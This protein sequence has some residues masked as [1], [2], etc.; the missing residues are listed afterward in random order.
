MPKKV[1]VTTG[2]RIL[3][4]QVTGGC[5]AALLA[6]SLVFTIAVAHAQS[7]APAPVP[8]TPPQS[9]AT[10][11]AETLPAILRDM[12]TALSL[13][14]SGQM[15][16]ARRLADDI[17]ARLRRLG[18]PGTILLAPA[19][20]MRASIAMQLGDDRTAES[21]FRSAIALREKTNGPNNVE[22]A[23]ALSGLLDLFMKRARYGEAEKLLRRVMAI[24]AANLPPNHPDRLFSFVTQANLDYALGRLEAA[25][26]TLKRVVAALRTHHPEH[27]YFGVALNNLGQVQVNLGL[28]STAEKT[29]NEV[30]AFQRKLSGPKS[31]LVAVA[32]NNLAG[33]YLRQGRYD[34]AERLHRAELRLMEERGGDSQELAKSISNLANVLSA[35]GRLREARVLMARALK[36][37]ERTLPPYHPLIATALNNLASVSANKTTAHY[38]TI[39]AML[40]RA[41]DI[42]T[43][44]YGNRHPLIA[45]ALNN[46][47]VSAFNQKRYG[48]A[49]TFARRAVKIV[50]V[51]FQGAHPE[52]ARALSTLATILN[53]RGKLE[54][55][56]SIQREAIRL[57]L[58]VLGPDHPDLALSWMNMASNALD[59]KDWKEAFDAGRRAS[60]IVARR[61]RAIIGSARGETENAI[62][63]L[64]V[65]RDS[66]LMV[67]VA[68]ERLSRTASPRD[69]KTLRNIAF[70]AAQVAGNNAANRALLRA[71]ARIA[72]RTPEIAELT[73]AR[74]DLS[75]R[76]QATETR[77]SQALGAPTTQQNAKLRERLRTELNT[78]RQTAADL[79]KRLAQSFPEYARLVE[80]NPL[81]ID[82]ARRRLAPDEA[83]V[84][85]V[86]TRFGTLVWAITQAQ[87]HLHRTQIDGKQLKTAIAA[88]RCGLDRSRW[89]G[90]GEAALAC[91]QR[92]K[93]VPDPDGPLPF[94]AV[95]AHRLYKQ[96]L[97]PVEP[98]IAG[99]HLLLVTADA[100]TTVPLQVL[101]TKPPQPVAD[102]S[103]TM[104]KLAWL[105]AR[106]PIT[107]LPAVASLATL[108]S[109]QSATRASKP[110][111]GFGNPLLVG[112]TGKDLRAF[113]RQSCAQVRS[114]SAQPGGKVDRRGTAASLR[115][116]P[117]LFLKLAPLPETANELCAVASALGADDGEVYLGARANLTT[118]RQL[119]RDGRLA[120]YRIVHFATHGLVARGVTEIESRLREPA[121]LLTPVTTGKTGPS[122]Q[123]AA[124]NGL[125][126]ASEIA[127]LN[128]NADWVVLSACNTASGGRPDA[129]ALSGLARAFFFAGARAL[130]VSHWP[131]RSDA[132]VELTTTAFLELARVPK[133]R[134]SEAMR[135]A[136]AK[137]INAGGIKAH[138]EY[139]APFV[140]VGDGGAL[141]R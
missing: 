138:P 128:L 108:R 44:L 8:G 133:L 74:Q 72:A 136:M 20:R 84:V 30:L 125:L 116:P 77:L 6:T 48:E 76:W 59:R 16:K 38:E 111:I 53:A 123:H 52:R 26:E 57:R 80:P 18:A 129:E 51:S 93:T 113:A 11:A 134:R 135:R 36:T 131:V 115:L 118:V 37:L 14:T 94:D 23:N 61:R 102:H 28:Y 79:D 40:Q 105:G 13:M 114:L 41:I 2:G 119:N 29:Y 95:R 55:A 98:I 103:H 49:E 127:G 42:R 9:R 121:I 62:G 54:E 5:A 4:A 140:V 64:N 130:L 50:E 78:I 43:K 96:L 45:S 86:P 25:H 89:H 110:F 87:V 33:L 3:R 32:L 1:P 22:T 24:R 63:Q 141:S 21:D 67:A 47:A 10:L 117:E 122:A 39:R 104:R 7:P 35:Q 17:V 120:R 75:E 46:L 106:Q 71:G 90:T 15:T 85:M 31:P 107:V 137:T 97:A 92:L 58:A 124:D 66:Y 91:V 56:R 88:L 69:A 139:W 65:L 126:R 82:Q 81:T 112:R 12:R 70:Q 109:G 132:A 100:L 34:E 83:L 27:G 68:A 73:R 19:L 60:Q 99:R 101:V